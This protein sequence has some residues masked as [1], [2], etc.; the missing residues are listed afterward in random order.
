MRFF[1]MILILILSASAE[2]QKTDLI[3]EQATKLY[4]NA[5]PMCIMKSGVDK[6]QVQ[7]IEA[8]ELVDDKNIFCYAGCILKAMDII[9]EKGT[10]KRWQLPDIFKALSGDDWNEN[11]KKLVKSVTKAF[12][13]SKDVCNSGRIAIKLMQTI[14]YQ[15]NKYFDF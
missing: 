2:L 7:K 1:G 10:L 12:E 15:N 5:R 11:T 9:G 14:F 3:I 13:S 4:L 8:G 6:F